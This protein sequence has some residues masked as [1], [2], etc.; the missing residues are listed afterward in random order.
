M[1]EPKVLMNVRVVVTQERDEG[2]CQ[3]RAFDDGVLM[4]GCHVPELPR[5]QVGDTLIDTMMYCAASNDL[6]PPEDPP[7][8]RPALKNNKVS[9]ALY[10]ASTTRRGD[11]EDDMID[12][13]I[14]IDGETFYV[15]VTREPTE[16]D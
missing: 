3:I 14:E 5:E 8:E 11:E 12:E 6:M 1:P 7:D 10:A 16:T 9:R 2:P 4:E 15:S 13:P